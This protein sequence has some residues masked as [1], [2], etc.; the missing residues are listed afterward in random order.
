MEGEGYSAVEVEEVGELLDDHEAVPGAPAEGVA[1]ELE[2]AQ[3]REVLEALDV[4][5]VS[6]AVGVGEEVLRIG[7]MWRTCSL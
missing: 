3:L 6:D 4:G 1:D 5:R 7:R 2:L